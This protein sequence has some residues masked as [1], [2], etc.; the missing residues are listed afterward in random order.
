MSVGCVFERERKG[1]EEVSANLPHDA[2]PSAMFMHACSFVC[3]CNIGLWVYV[4]FVS[5][6]CLQRLGSLKT[7]NFCLLQSG[8]QSCVIQ[9]G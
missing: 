1:S 3:V 5:V 4:V 7:A 9:D 8:T 2:L 6:I